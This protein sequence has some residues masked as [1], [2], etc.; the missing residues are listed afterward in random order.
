MTNTSQSIGDL[1]LRDLAFQVQL[2]D[3]A[4]KA[5]GG[6]DVVPSKVNREVTPE[7]IADFEDAKKVSV[8]GPDGQE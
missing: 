7:M 4:E 3:I 1:A 6:K 5:V 8:V 2:D